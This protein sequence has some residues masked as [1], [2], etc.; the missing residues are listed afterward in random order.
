VSI[1][2]DIRPRL[3]RIAKELAKFGSV[4]AIAFGITAVLNSMLYG[5]GMGPMSSLAIATVVATTFSYFANRHWTF[6]HRDR[7]DVR[8]EYAVFFGLNAVGLV[9]SELVVGFNHYVLGLHSS[10]SNF[11]ALL[12]GTAIATLF[13]FWAYRKWVFQAPAVLVEAVPV[14]ASYAATPAAFTAQAPTQR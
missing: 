11:A 14:R 9:I 6:K 10:F 2:A 12:V 4:G 13:R 5:M 7:S 8:R 1:V 3:R